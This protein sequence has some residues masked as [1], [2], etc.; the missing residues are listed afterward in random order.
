MTPVWIALSA[1]LVIATI[2][3]LSYFTRPRLWRAG[4]RR[5]AMNQAARGE[6]KRQSTHAL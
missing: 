3:A 5:A 2:G 6:R 4:V 1:A